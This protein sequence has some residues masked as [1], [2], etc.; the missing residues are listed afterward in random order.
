MMARE[1]KLADDVSL[2]KSDESSE[3]GVDEVEAVSAENSSRHDSDNCGQ[4]TSNGSMGREMSEVEA[5]AREDTNML[6]V[7]RRVVAVVI[8]VT[9]SSV[10]TGAIIFLKKEESDSSHQSVSSLHN[11]CILLSKASKS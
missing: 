8:I 6:R 9:F 5:M 11:A 4:S 2:C 7:W 3:S 10:L 1:D